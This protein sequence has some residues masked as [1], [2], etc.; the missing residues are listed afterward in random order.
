[1]RLFDSLAPLGMLVLAAVATGCVG[2]DPERSN[3]YVDE[4][5]RFVTVDYAHEEHETPFI[6]PDGREMMFKSNLK[7]RVT[8]PDETSFVGYQHMSTMGNL[9]KAEDREWEFLEEG[10]GCA[11]ARRAPDGKGYLLYF[12]GV[13]CGQTRLK[14][15]EVRKKRT[16]VR[17]QS[18]SSTPQGFGRDSTGPRDSSGPRTVEEAN[19]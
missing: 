7:V 15:E 18:G 6:A 14:T 12:Q 5:G 10:T 8:L 4:R 3:R 9:F 11:V 1:M 2:F 13:L 19:K 16:N 17:T